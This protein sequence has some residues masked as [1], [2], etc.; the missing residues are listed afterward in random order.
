MTLTHPPL[1]KSFKNAFPFRLAAPSYVYPGDYALNIRLLGPFVDEIE[2]LLFE[3]LTENALP[4]PDAFAEMARLSRKFGLTL[5][6]HL[7]IDVSLAHPDPNMRK[8]AVKQLVRAM[9]AASVLDPTSMTLHIDCHEKDLSRPGVKKW[10]KRVDAG[11]QRL[12]DAGTKAE[13]LCVETLD[14]PFE[15]IEDTVLSHG[16]SVCLDLGHLALYGRDIE[17][18]FDRMGSRVRVV[19]LHGV[20]DGR[21]HLSLDQMDKALLERVVA[22]LK[23]FSGS[24]CLETFS[25]EKLKRSLET[26]EKAWGT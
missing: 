21:D 20:R 8:T 22:R 19:H 14:Y 24:L 23:G 11:L 10:R 25:Y 18:A 16:L 15:I 26:F 5:N 3:S 6:V 9:D 4:S 13:T 1:P 12:L 17:K 7:P 2:I